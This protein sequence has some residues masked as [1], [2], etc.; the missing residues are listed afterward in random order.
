CR[1]VK[2]KRLFLYLA[3]KAA[4]SWTGSLD[5]SRINLGKGD[6]LIAE[7]GVLDKKYRIT[8]PRGL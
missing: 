5:V 8:V 3:E 4:H 7:K 2:V 1:S 6:R